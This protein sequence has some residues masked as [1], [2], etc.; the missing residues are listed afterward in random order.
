MLNAFFRR[1][2]NNIIFEVF[3][4]LFATDAICTIL[5]LS[6]MNPLIR[7]YEKLLPDD[8]FEKISKAMYITNINALPKKDWGS[9]IKKEMTRI[10]EKL[11]DFFDIYIFKNNYKVAEH[12]L[13]SNGIIIGKILEMY[14]EAYDD[15]PECSE[16][17]RLYEKILILN[18][19]NNAV[20]KVVKTLY[21]SKITNYC[22]IVDAMLQ[23][24]HLVLTYISDF[25]KKDKLDSELLDSIHMCVL[26]TKRR[27]ELLADNFI[28]GNNEYK[29][30]FRFEFA[31]SYYDVLHYCRA[32]VESHTNT[33]PLSATAT[34]SK[35]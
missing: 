25:I 15:D 29:D 31:S 10:T 14:K 7:I 13:E 5:T 12:I 26:D 21:D 8:Q 6:F 28:L 17:R 3:L 23:H 16:D 19:L 2:Y 30:S 1:I 22:N 33:V 27:K 35:T 34:N 9:L 18:N 32:F 4:T 24:I 11:F 20:A